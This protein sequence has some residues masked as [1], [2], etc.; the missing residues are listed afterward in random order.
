MGEM[1][2]KFIES[3][4]CIQLGAQ[5]TQHR[6]EQKLM[7]FNTA[8]FL[9]S[10]EA[11]A[12]LDLAPGAP[13]LPGLQYARPNWNSSTFLP[14]QPWWEWGEKWWSKVCTCLFLSM[15]RLHTAGTLF[16]MSNVLLGLGCGWS[17]N[18]RTNSWKQNL[19]QSQ[20]SLSWVGREM[21]FFLTLGCYICK[22]P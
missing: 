21:T 15:T 2:L 7:F 22:H 17:L 1:K 3:K 11:M 6:G 12:E 13:L 8:T 14:C 18:P 9:K 19:T 20:K 5:S 10:S 4:D 16:K